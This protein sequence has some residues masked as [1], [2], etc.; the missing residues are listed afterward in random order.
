MHGLGLDPC[1]PPD[2][3]AIISEGGAWMPSSSPGSKLSLSRGAS[4]SD[5]VVVLLDHPEQPE[6][7]GKGLGFLRTL[8]NSHWRTAPI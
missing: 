5:L 6:A 7:I 1:I 8:L 4:A 3:P 2:A